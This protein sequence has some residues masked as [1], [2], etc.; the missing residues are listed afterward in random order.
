MRTRNNFSFSICFWA[1]LAVPAFPAFAASTNAQLRVEIRGHD[2]P[3]GSLMVA[4]FD[5]ARE[6]PSGKRVR[7]ATLPLTRDPSNN[8]M[9]C[10]F[11][12]PAGRYGV[13]VIHDRNGNGR[14]DTNFIG[15]P[16]ERYGFSRNPG[17]HIGPP[18]FDHV[19]ID[20][21]S[22]GLEISILLR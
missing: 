8:T 1:L 15:I 12:L 10:S 16:R 14:M 9:R 20:L 22:G 19:A 11:T 18:P 2:G 3:T 17:F 5:S 21:P 7:E 4:V 6:F 13:A